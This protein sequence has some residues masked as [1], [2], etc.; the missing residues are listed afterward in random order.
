VK[1][2]HDKKLATELKKRLQKIDYLDELVP[3]KLSE[4]EQKKLNDGSRKY[5]EQLEN[6]IN[7]YVKQLKGLQ[8]L[9]AIYAFANDESLFN[10]RLKSSKKFVKN[11][12]EDHPLQDIFGLKLH[13]GHTSKKI[14]STEEREEYRLHD[15]IVTYVYESIRVISNV[16]NQIIEQKIV[17]YADFYIFLKN[18]KVPDKNDFDIIM[19]GILEHYNRR[20]LSSISILTPKIE[21]TLYDYLISINA[22]VSC[23]TEETISKR[24]LGGLIDLPEI[25]KNFS[26]DF[27]YFLKLL[28]VA[29]DSINFRNRFAHGEVKIEELNETCSS[30][31]IFILLKICGKTLKSSNLQQPKR[32]RTSHV[33]STSN[34]SKTTM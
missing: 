10:M 22:D 15:F 14:G 16:F 7:D 30:I 28:L 17:N 12:M 6:S 18:C 2:V 8:P 21:S 19:N 32:K 24:T 34:T 31:I 1:Y 23:Y 26:I 4:E 29:D 13:L 27:Q 33:Q 9:Q 5:A 11:L 3:I 20:F 25:E